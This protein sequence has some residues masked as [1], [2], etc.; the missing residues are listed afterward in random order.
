MSKNAASLAE[1]GLQVA[2]EGLAGKLMDAAVDALKGQV[3]EDKEIQVACQVLA[4]ATARIACVSLYSLPKPMFDRAM[5]SL[6]DAIR[7]TAEETRDLI[8]KEFRK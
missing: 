4:V 8:D 7:L 6:I 2:N 1:V 5:M 3:P